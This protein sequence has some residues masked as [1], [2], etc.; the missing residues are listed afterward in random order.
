MIETFERKGY[1]QKSDQAQQ[2]AFSIVELFI[3]AFSGAW[4]VMRERRDV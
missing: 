3:R 1:C 2:C 4:E